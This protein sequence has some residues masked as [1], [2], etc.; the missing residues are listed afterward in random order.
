MHRRLR[1]SLAAAALLPIAGT[2][3]EFGEAAASTARL[4]AMFD[5]PGVT[6]EV[7]PVVVSGGHAIAGAM[8][9]W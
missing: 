2:R 9:A 6:L 1:W 8:A 3:A 5:R 7:A 4:H